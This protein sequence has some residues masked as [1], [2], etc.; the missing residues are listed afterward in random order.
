VVARWDGADPLA[1]DGPYGEY[2]LSRVAKVFPHL[3]AE[4]IPEVDPD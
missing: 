4:V 1:Y 2:L 3:F